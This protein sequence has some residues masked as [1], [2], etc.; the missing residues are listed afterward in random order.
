MVKDLDQLCEV[1]ECPT[2]PIYLLNDDRINTTGLDVRQQPGERRSRDGQFDP[3]GEE[4]LVSGSANKF[5]SGK[6][7]IAFSGQCSYNGTAA[8]LLRGLDVG[9]CV[10]EYQMRLAIV[11]AGDRG[12]ARQGLPL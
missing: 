5:D 1:H 11:A 12:C 10:S 7:S 6:N 2:Q 9:H 3:F 4:F 8:I